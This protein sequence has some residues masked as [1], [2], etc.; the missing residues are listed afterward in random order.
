MGTQQISSIN[1]LHTIGIKP[2]CDR[3]AR[4][5]CNRE[6]RKGKITLGIIIEALIELKW[7]SW[8]SGDLEREY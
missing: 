2:F 5:G 3:E 7:L 1:F 6:S 8:M 4:Q